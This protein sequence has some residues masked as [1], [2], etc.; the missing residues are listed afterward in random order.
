M[1][2]NISI[3]N[4]HRISWSA[5]LRFGIESQLMDIFLGLRDL[6]RRIRYNAIDILDSAVLP[7]ANLGDIC[8]LLKLPSLQ[9]S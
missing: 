9:P 4:W 1:L 5:D 8:E 3:A 6:M 2:R 7:T